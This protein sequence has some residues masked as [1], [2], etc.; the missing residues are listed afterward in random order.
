VGAVTLDASV[1]IAV[2]DPADAHHT[3]AVSALEAVVDS[4]EEMTIS[5]SAYAEALVHPMRDRRGDVVDGFLDRLGV[6]IAEL[7]RP[8]ARRAAALRADHASLRLPDAIVLA[9][10]QETDARLLTFDDRLD[11]FA[12]GTKPF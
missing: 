2:L 5:A 6:A 12:S 9:T 11:R 8:L 10:A 4:G 7:D 1:V 3:E